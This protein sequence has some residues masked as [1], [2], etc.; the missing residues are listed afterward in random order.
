MDVD[1]EENT[2][3]KIGMNTEAFKDLVE[4]AENEWFVNNKGEKKLRSRKLRGTWVNSFKKL[5]NE[6]EK[7]EFKMLGIIKIIIFR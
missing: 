6:Y 1:L 4:T 2:Q 5:V 7:E 3:Y